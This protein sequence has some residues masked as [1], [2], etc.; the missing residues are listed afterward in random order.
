MNAHLN[1]GLTVVTLRNRA[2]DW[3]WFVSFGAVAYLG[4]DGGGYSPVAHGQLGVLLWW[5]IGLGLL[6]GVLPLGRIGRSGWLAAGLLAALAGLDAPVAGLDGQ[7]PRPP[8]PR[9][10]V[11]PPTS[12]YWCLA[13]S[14]A[15]TEASDR[16]I[17][18]SRH[19]RADPARGRRTG[20]AALP[21]R[22]PG[23]SAQRCSWTSA[24]P[25]G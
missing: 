20:V 14:C 21:G 7:R 23:K 13:W 6:L 2:P 1:R 25:R 11:Q 9:R 5:G 22:F 15:G 4:L 8:G 12:A 17:A 24:T 18:G 3:I 19:R 16:S 10:D